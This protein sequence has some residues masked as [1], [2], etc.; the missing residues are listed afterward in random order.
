MVVAIEQVR[1]KAGVQM[2]GSRALL[3][4]S[5]ANDLNLCSFPTTIT[6]TQHA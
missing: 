6:N 3:L 2:K 1:N 5:S 4:C